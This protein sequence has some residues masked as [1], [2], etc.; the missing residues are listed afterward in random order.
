VSSKTLRC[1]LVAFVL[2]I[3]ATAVSGSASALQPRRAGQQNSLTRAFYAAGNL[4]LL[5]DAGELS[6]I[7]EGTDSRIEETLPEPALDLCMQDGHPVVITCQREHCS[8]WT[9]RGRIDGVW[10]VENTVQTQG[11]DLLG[12]GCAPKR[13]TLLTS[14]RLIDSGKEKQ[15]SVILSDELEPDLFIS[16]LDAPD[17]VL[18]G[19]NEGEWGGGLWSIDRHTGQVASIERYATGSPCGGPLNSD[20]DPV[21]G[22]AFEPWKPQCVAATI[23]LVH[24]T[25]HGRIVEVCGDDARRLYYKPTEKPL[26]GPKKGEGNEPS[27]TVAFF[28]LTRGG[29]AL[30]AAGTDG[31]YRIDADGVTRYAPLPKFKRIG[32]VDVS[33]ELPH[34]VVM[35]TSIAA[36]RSVSSALP[37]IVPR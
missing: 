13:I 7:R 22:M 36:R 11:D 14:R 10:R 20:C 12:L 3:L 8:N 15:T 25:A 37:L 6:S 30:W 19:A 32:G 16:I 27:E 17:R 21:N 34:F 24:F 29:D 23:G 33:F 31:I 2:A 28:G 4:W 5:S 9:V 18:V 1:R 26:F 35:L